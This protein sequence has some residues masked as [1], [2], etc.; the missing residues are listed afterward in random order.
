M[1][2]PTPAAPSISG[3]QLLALLALGVGAIGLRSVLVL[4]QQF[5][6][7]Q[8]R[9][10][11]IAVA[12]IAV[13]IAVFIIGISGLTTVVAALG[14]AVG[15]TAGF[16]LLVPITP[17]VQAAGPC[18]GARLARADF[19]AT[20]S[21]IG[22]NARAGPG[23][24]YSPTVRFG[25]DCTLAFVGFCYGEPTLDEFILDRFRVY[26]T[27]WLALPKGQGYIASGVLKAQRAEASLH[28]LQ[29]CPVGTTPPE[30]PVL[31][32]VATPA[33]GDV[34]LNATA[35]NA[36]TVGFATLA[37]TGSAPPA[38][39][40]VALATAPVGGAF[41]ATWSTATQAT[42]GGGNGVGEVLLVSVVCAAAEVPTDLVADQIVVLAN[43]NGVA[44][45]TGFN[46]RTF[47]ALQN[48]NP[49]L[50]ERLRRTA[51]LLPD[52]S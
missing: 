48:D 41:T 32:R 51:C 26:D 52:P 10:I 14:A 39:R 45:A 38:L 50:A 15:L 40:R 12:G 20:T 47:D 22:V 8:T 46:S 31:S 29:D 1:T 37:E 4:S 36:F 2:S 21:P 49:A 42:V 30:R 43:P 6:S 19:L 9:L 27:R 5:S 25:G 44:P 17:A 23:R 11:D 3:M 28:L 18:S 33:T 16:Q 34:V 13:G 7:D 35:S 24:S